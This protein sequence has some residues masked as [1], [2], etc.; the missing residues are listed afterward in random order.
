MMAA[1]AALALVLGGAVEAV[2]LKRQR[3]EYRKIAAEHALDEAL[4][5]GM[6]ND[7]IDSAQLYESLQES[8]RVFNEIKSRPRL[9]GPAGQ[10][11][12]EM[13]LLGAELGAQGKDDAAQERAG[14]ALYHKSAA[15]HAAL[16]KKYLAAAAHPWRAIEPDPP[17][18][19]PQARAR[20]LERKG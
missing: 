2:R 11:I 15:Y 10:Q 17:P 16:K 8:T 13:S 6:E 1:I 14:A 18:P 7:A 20:F 5:R 9:Q 12:R 4:Y 3:D 19:A